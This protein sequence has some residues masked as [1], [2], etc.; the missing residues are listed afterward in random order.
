MVL[1]GDS[2]AMQLFPALD[3]DR[4]ARHWRLVQLTKARLPAAAR[5][6]LIFTISGP[7]YRECDTWRD[8]ALRRIAAERPVLVVATS[9]AH[10][11][12]LDAKGRRM[13]RDAGAA[14]LAGAYPAALRRL[15]SRRAPR[16]RRRRPAA[17]AARRPGLRLR[18]SSIDLRRCAFAPARRSRAHG[19]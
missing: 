11:T 3:A 18:V 17:T 10:Y 9:S 5:P 6:R 1:F 15:R 8:Y 14:A 13:D 16:R 19:S 2:H 12:V 4:G 7:Q